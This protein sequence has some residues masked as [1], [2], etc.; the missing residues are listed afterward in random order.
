MNAEE[1]PAFSAC[2][3]EAAETLKDLSIGALITQVT[4]SG[5]QD[6]CEQERFDFT[7][8]PFTI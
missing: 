1:P 2:H 8:V 5:G 6:G 3:P 4:L 7:R